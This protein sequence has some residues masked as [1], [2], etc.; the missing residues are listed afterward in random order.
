[1]E[2]WNIE[3]HQIRMEESSSNLQ[4]QESAPLADSWES[5]EVGELFLVF[6]EVEGVENSRV[7]MTILPHLNSL[8]RTISNIQAQ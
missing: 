4:K 5:H 1:M 3:D 6:W 8:D 2:V 7:L